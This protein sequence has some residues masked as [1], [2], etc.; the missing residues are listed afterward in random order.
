MASGGN[1]AVVTP[2]GET[3]RAV[4][5][6][7]RHRL[8]SVFHGVGALV[9]SRRPSP[10]TVP[11]LGV[12]PGGDWFASRRDAPDPVGHPRRRPV[13]ADKSALVAHYQAL[14]EDAARERAVADLDRR[15]RALADRTT[16]SRELWLA[17]AAPTPGGRRHG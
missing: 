3:L 9:T 4:P 7:A 5:R 8:R 17:G 13:P 15:R 10:S 11:T 6:R 16:V 14:A 12:A 2:G 1:G